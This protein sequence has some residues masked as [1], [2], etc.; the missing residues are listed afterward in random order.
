[1]GRLGW[2]PGEVAEVSWETAR[3]KSLAIEVAGWAGHRPGQH[4]DLRLTAQDGYQAVRSYSL[5]SAPDAGRLTVTVERIDDGEVSPYLVDEARPGDR[6]EVRGPIGGYFVWEPAMGGPLMLV[7]GG[8][9]V[10]PLAAMIRTRAAVDASVPVRLLYSSRAPEDVIFAAELDR[11]AATS[12][13][14]EIVHTFTRSP[15]P[16]W[17]G[18]RRRIDRPML[19]EVAWPASSGALAY[20]CGPTRLVERVADDLLAIGYHPNRTRTERFGPTGG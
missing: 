11:L 7:G 4:V 13:G 3:V 5:S 12:D 1:L 10:V 18:H 19:E 2:A 17:T 15:P 16:G 20:T 8:S 6:L 9:G 14:L